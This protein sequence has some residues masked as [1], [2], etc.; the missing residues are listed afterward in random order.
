MLLSSRSVP[1][2]ITAP[3]KAL[4]IGIFLAIALSAS[5]E[6]PMDNLG[7]RGGV[8]A[9]ITLSGVAFGAGV[10]KLF[11][12][13]FEVGLVFYYGSFE[14]NSSSGIYTYKDTTQVIAL[15]AQVNYLYGYHRDRGG[16]YLVGGVGLAYLGINWEES[17]PNDTS[18]GTLLPGGGSKQAF[19]GSVGGTI[20]TLGA[21]YTIAGGLDVRLE[22]PLVISFSAAGGASTLIP[23]FTLTAG[24][25]LGP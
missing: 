15:A 3:K 24:Y 22:V 1:R 20:L 6:G 10:N 5:A 23:L 25:R 14:E 12:D 2:R 11:M 7:V 19:D 17:S 21:G 18:L 4:V 8:G 13:Q 9:D 16:F